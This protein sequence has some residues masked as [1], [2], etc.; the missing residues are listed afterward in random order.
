MM[1]VNRGVQK[2]VNFNELSCRVAESMLGGGLPF[3]R[4][5]CDRI[6]IVAS[7]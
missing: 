6:A 1:N 7:G 2:R 5:Q 4:Y 3:H